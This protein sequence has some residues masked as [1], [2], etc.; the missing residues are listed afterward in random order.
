[1]TAEAEHCVFAVR[2]QVSMTLPRHALWQ[3]AATELNGLTLFYDLVEKSCA[4]RKLL[5]GESQVREGWTSMTYDS[6]L[7]SF[8]EVV[9]PAAQE[10]TEKA[11]AASG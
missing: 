5:L 6:A 8:R 3:R 11:P 10:D 7:G 9:P 4:G 1:M 2:G